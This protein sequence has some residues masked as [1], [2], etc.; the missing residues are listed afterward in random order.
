MARTRKAIWRML[1]ACLGLASG[2]LGAE[3]TFGHLRAA[4]DAPAAAVLYSIELRNGQGDL[5]ANPVVVGQEGRKVHLDLGAT[6]LD[7]LRSEAPRSLSLDLDP[8]PSE[9][10][11]CLGYKLSLDDGLHHRGRVRIP[12]GV[13]GGLVLLQGGGHL[14][15]RAARAHT[16]EFRQLM[17]LRPYRPAA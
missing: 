1:V 6:P 8:R 4:P 7:G 3:M 2:I 14:W 13:D 10:G 17:S 16:P 5:V 11:L 15:L 9:A 12:Y